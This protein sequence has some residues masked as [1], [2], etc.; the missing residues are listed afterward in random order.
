MIVGDAHRKSAFTGNHFVLKSEAMV[1]LEFP[2]P[3]KPGKH[4]LKAF[5]MSDSY[6]YCDQ[7]ET[8]EIDTGPDNKSRISAA[9]DVEIE[10]GSRAGNDSFDFVKCPPKIQQKRKQFRND[11]LHAV[12]IMI[13]FTELMLDSW[14]LQQSN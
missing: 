14:S 7:E 1:K 10:I 3:L 5:L 9:D 4:S 2:S 6:I 12:R 13:L 8:F 11:N